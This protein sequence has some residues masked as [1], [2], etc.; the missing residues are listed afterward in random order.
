MLVKVTEQL[1]SLE[2][3]PLGGPLLVVI[4]GP[5]GVGKDSTLNR[6]KVMD[7]PWHFVITVTTRPKRDNERDGQDYTFVTLSQFEVMRE[8][9]DLLEYAQVYGH[10]Y[11]V[12]KQQVLDALRRRDDVILKLDVQGAATVKKIIPTAVFIFLGPPTL[13]DL[14]SRLEERD[15]ESDSSIDLRVHAA[16]GEMASMSI[17]DYYV[18]SRYGRLDDVV[19]CIDSIVTAEKCRI[20]PREV[21]CD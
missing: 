16:E 9:G 12:P 14:K 17:F 20:P 6:M 10:W 2:K 7:R 8:Q 5:S 3:V 13:Q 15:T 21:Y 4:S 19:A 11:G 18:V 1:E